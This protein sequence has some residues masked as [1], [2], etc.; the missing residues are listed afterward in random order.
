ML[1]LQ[2]KENLVQLFL[3]EVLQSIFALA[4]GSVKAQHGAEAQT[5]VFLSSWVEE[6]Q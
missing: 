6:H 5:E 4:S 2:Y 1:W 3:F